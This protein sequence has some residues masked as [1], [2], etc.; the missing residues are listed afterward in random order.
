M[1]YIWVSE[2]SGITHTR[3]YVGR[4]KKICPNALIG[5][6]TRLEREPKCHGYVCSGLDVVCRDNIDAD[7]GV[8]GGDLGDFDTRD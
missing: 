3:T 6:Y 4:P 8:W 5:R 7:G 2:K 1:K